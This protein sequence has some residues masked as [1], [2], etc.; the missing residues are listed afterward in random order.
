MLSTRLLKALPIP[1]FLVLLLALAACSS[2]SPAPSATSTPSGPQPTI[3]LRPSS[4]PLPTETAR[5][6]FTPLPSATATITVTPTVTPDPAL[7][8]VRLLGPS[9]LQDYNLLIT[10]IFPGPVQPD[11]YRVMVED[12]P[13]ECQVLPQYPD[14]LYCIGR[15]RNVYGLITVRVYQPGSEQPGFEGKLSVPFFK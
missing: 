1:L 14:R 12:K 8:E 15:G 10:L 3:T 13:Y 5:P 9:W 7:S 2:A 11:Q 4:T 6:T